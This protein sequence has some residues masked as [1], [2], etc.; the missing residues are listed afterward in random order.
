MGTS[1]LVVEQAVLHILQCY[2]GMTMDEVC[3][4]MQPDLTWSEVFLALDRLSRN[5]QIALFRTGSTYR[6]ALSSQA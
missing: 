6:V 2:G 3:N 4:L 5:Q 1:S